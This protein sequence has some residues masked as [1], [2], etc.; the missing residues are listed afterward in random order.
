MWILNI[1]VFASASENGAQILHF[2]KIVLKISKNS[3]AL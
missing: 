2:K 1:C 3:E